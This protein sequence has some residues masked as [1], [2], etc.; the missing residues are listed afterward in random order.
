[1]V[2]KLQS[3]PS[4]KSHSV[5]PNIARYRPGALRLFATL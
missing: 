2:G 4:L 5:D 1:M 3:L